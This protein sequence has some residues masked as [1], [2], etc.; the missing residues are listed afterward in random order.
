MNRFVM[1]LRIS[2]LVL[3]LAGFSF[4]AGK[5]EVADAVMNNDIVALRALLRQKGDVNAAQVDGSTALH[6]AVFRDRVAAARLLIDAGAK[7]DAI[8]R[9]G[10]TPLYMASLYGN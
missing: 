3:C 2:A 9:E 7:A 8:N 10:I 6:W 1:S 5:A 4:A